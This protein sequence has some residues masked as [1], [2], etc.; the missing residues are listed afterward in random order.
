[1]GSNKISELLRLFKEFASSYLLTVKGRGLLARYDEARRQGC[2]NFEAAIA[3]AENG[4]DVTERVLLKLL[5]HTESASNRQKEAWIHIAPGISEDLMEWF[6]RSGWAKSCDW[7]LIAKAILHFVRCCTEEPDQLSSACTEFSNLPYCKGFQTE[8]LS[9]IISALR[10]HDFLL[11][12]KKSLQVL[13]YF[14]D[15]SF[16]QN[17]IDYP[18]MNAS[19][20]NLIEEVAKHMGKFDLP[21]FQEVDIFY[22]F[23]HWLVTI[24]RYGLKSTPFAISEE[25]YKRWPPL[26]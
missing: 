1:M 24:K 14:A 25:M 11:I 3:A 8:M 19:G 16:S 5:P 22:M 12:D 7:P 21:E 15:K 10:P 2:Q 17:L 20:H 26:W 13:N 18:A 6:Q 23:S 4:E 9:P